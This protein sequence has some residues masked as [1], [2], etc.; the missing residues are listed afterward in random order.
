MTPLK[1]MNCQQAMNQLPDGITSNARD[2]N[3][4]GYI[5][6][7]THNELLDK[8]I[9]EEPPQIA[10]H[11][12]T[13]KPMWG[14]AVR[15]SDVLYLALEDTEGHLQ[16][17]GRDIQDQIIWVTRN[18]ENLTWEFE[19]RE[20]EIPDEPADPLLETIKQLLTDSGSHWEGSSTE[21]AAVLQTE[22]APSALSRKLNIRASVL[23]NDYHI[24]Y[25]NVHTRE[26]SLLTLHLEQE[27]GD[28][29]DGVTAKTEEASC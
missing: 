21:L 29:C 15:Q 9:I 14:M 13:G 26:G 18:L 19:S 27:N 5:Y 7:I 24:Q 2:L 17:T 28:A 23:L 20:N 16:C 4:P 3:S 10:C 11:V 22:M 8:V 12:S 1:L 6:T 25:K